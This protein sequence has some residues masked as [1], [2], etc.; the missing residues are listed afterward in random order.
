MLTPGK[1][2]RKL[3]AHAVQMAYLAEV[4][5]Q[6]Q[7]TAFYKLLGARQ[8][9]GCLRRVYTQNIDALEVKA[10]L[11]TE[12]NNPKCVQLHGSAMEVIFTQC[13]FTEHVHH[14]FLSLKSG[15]LPSC[16]QCQN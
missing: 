11:T 6:A 2:P 9:L 5:A 4:A 16:P 13:S 10:G 3:A 1:N 7:P 12:G 15:E 14:H 8:S